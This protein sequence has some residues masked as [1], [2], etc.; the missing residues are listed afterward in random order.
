[1]GYQNREIC[2][3]LSS[4]DDCWIDDT[5]T[6]KHPP[7][8]MKRRQTPCRRPEYHRRDRIVVPLLR[9]K[10]ANGHVNPR[11]LWDSTWIIV[12]LSSFVN[13]TVTQRDKYECR[14]FR[15]RSGAQL[16]L[17]HGEFHLTLPYG[18]NSFAQ[19]SKNLAKYKSENNFVWSI[20]II[21]KILKLIVKTSK[22]FCSLVID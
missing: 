7:L 3:L 18:K 15:T 22:L 20:N 8:T 9:M 17:F 1:M 21:C 16:I 13:F 14:R 12:R 10:S 2:L 4:D 6:M 5:L 19:V 11:D